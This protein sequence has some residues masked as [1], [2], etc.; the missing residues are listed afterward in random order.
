[1][2]TDQNVLDRYFEMLTETF[3]DNGLQNK[4]TQ[5]YNCDETG[6]LLGM[7]SLK[8]VAKVILSYALLLA[9]TRHK[10]LSCHV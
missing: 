1:M 3:S 5:I 10:L 6:M 4:P 8:V 9:V 2:A 7:S